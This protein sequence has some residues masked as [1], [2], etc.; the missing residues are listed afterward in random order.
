MYCGV[1]TQKRTDWLSL[2]TPQYYQVWGD[3]RIEHEADG[4]CDWVEG[5][6]A[7]QNFIKHWNID[8]VKQWIIVGL[9]VAG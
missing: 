7:F 9:F 6:G 8:F 2:H 5:N 3:R 4:S 1:L